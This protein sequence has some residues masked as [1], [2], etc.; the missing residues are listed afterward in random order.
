[1]ACG[2]DPVALIQQGTTLN[3]RVFVSTLESLPELLLKE[4]IKAPTLIIV[5]EVVQLHENS[6]G[7]CH[8]LPRRI[9]SAVGSGLAAQAMFHRQ[10]R[11]L[12][13]RANAELAQN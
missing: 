7:F 13:A 2:L 1:M 12:D 11:C 3:Q 9:D 10:H 6:T 4:S 5:G 8:H